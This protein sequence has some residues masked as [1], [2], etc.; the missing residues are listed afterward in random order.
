MSHDC[1]QSPGYIFWVV[2]TM[3]ASNSYQVNNYFYLYGHKQVNV[4]V[5]MVGGRI[6]RI[7]CR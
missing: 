6:K 2:V 7:A 4:F 3:E 5:L 1:K